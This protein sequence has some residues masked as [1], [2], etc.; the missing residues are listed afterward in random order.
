MSK[1]VSNLFKELRILCNKLSVECYVISN[2][3]YVISFRISIC[4]LIPKIIIKHPLCVR[5]WG[6]QKRLKYTK[7]PERASY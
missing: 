2:K 4:F 7:I 6:I 1:N 3:L 5:H